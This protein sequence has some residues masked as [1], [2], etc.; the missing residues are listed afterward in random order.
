MADLV[1]LSPQPSSLAYAADAFL[2]HIDVAA[3]AADL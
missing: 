3:T 2:D 1:A